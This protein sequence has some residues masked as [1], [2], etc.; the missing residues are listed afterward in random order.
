LDVNRRALGDG[1]ISQQGRVLLDGGSRIPV[2]P[3]STARLPKVETRS[4]SFSSMPLMPLTLP[5]ALAPASEIQ[6]ESPHFST[7][8]TTAFPTIGLQEQPNGR[9]PTLVLGYLVLSLPALAKELE[10][11]RNS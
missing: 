11:C 10:Q 8:T 2:P 1:E 5:A 4:G 6:R 3:R 9:R 7:L